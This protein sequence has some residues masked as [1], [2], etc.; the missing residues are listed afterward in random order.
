[1]SLQI[2]LIDDDVDDQLIFTEIIEE[3]SPDLQCITARNGLEG[4]EKL[5]GMD[6]GPA[7][8]FLDLNMPFISGWEC[9][10]RIRKDEK[11][12]QIPVVI[13]TTSDNQA[14]KKRSLELGA[15]AFVTKTADLASLRQIV[16]KMLTAQA[17]FPGS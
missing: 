4:L 8:I 16:R 15:I 2:L 10:E 17:S 5:A 12:K 14:D 6:P 11:T 7:M 3:I 1:M 13:M 9:L